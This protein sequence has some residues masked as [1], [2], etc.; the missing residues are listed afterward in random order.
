MLKVSRNPSF[1]PGE[2]GKVQKEAGSGVKCLTV[3]LRGRLA[4]LESHG[5]AIKTP[6]TCGRNIKMAMTR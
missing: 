1:R 4:P 3:V 5:M 6:K 2:L